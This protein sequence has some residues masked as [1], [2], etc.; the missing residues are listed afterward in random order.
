MGQQELEAALRRE[1]E[2]KAR[3]IWRTVESEAGRLRCETATVLDRQ[4]QVGAL[5]RNTE[6]FAVLETARSV[7]RQKAQRSRLVSEDN[8]VKRLKLLAG[9]MLE[10]LALLGGENLFS[11]LVDEIPE[12]DWFQVRVHPRD[13]ELA[14]S[15][16]PTAEIVTTERISG[17]L[18]VESLEGRI[19]IINSL[20]KRIEHL[21]PEI[22]PVMLRE[23]RQMKDVNDAVA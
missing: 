20:E 10:T 22:L 5:R 7:A 8:L 14:S 23:L 15:R 4:Q 16:F 19:V 11:A 12:Y 21:W 1:G 13:L 9:Q 2:E 17:G 18:Q 6:V 3:E